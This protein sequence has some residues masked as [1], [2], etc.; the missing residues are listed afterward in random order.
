MNCI[1]PITWWLRCVVDTAN[2]DKRQYFG[3]HLHADTS[4]FDVDVDL[5]SPWTKFESCIPGQRCIIIIYGA[6]KVYGRGFVK[7]DHSAT[8]DSAWWLC[9]F[10]L[11]LTLVSS[12]T[13]AGWAYVSQK[14]WSFNTCSCLHSPRSPLVW[15]VRKQNRSI[16][17]PRGE[18]GRWARW[19]RCTAKRGYL[20]FCR[21]FCGELL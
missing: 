9:R 11:L 17:A 7:S 16:T 1:P 6:S 3:W 19:P 13:T 21:Y 10:I 12:H 5:Y 2:A 18:C 8:F 15:L 4:S 14:A 20:L